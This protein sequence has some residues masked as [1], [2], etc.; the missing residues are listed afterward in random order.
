MRKEGEGRKEGKKETV[1][2]SK[3]E[4]SMLVSCA[5]TAELMK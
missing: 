1:T 2:D 3:G 5:P 4:K